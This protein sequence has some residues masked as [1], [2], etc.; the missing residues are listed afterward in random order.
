MKHKTESHPESSKFSWIVGRLG[1]S[2]RPAVLVALIAALA[3]LCMPAMART[4]DSPEVLEAQQ[5]TRLLWTAGEFELAIVDTEALFERFP[6][7]PRGRSAFFHIANELENTC[8]V[9]ARSL[10]E[11]ADLYA[12]AWG[13]YVKSSES[14]AT[15]SGGSLAVLAERS[16]AGVERTNKLIAEIKAIRDGRIGVRAAESALREYDA[17]LAAANY[18]EEL[19]AAGGENETKE[20]ELL[21]LLL[22][23]LSEH[24]E[25]IAG[26]MSAARNQLKDDHP[27]LYA[28]SYAHNE[29]LEAEAV[30]RSIQTATLAIE[31][32]ADSA[33]YLDYRVYLAWAH[34]AEA[35]VE[36]G[37]LERFALADDSEGV[38][39]TFLA[40]VGAL[41]AVAEQRQ[42]IVDFADA[43]L[44][45]ESAQTKMLDT[46]YG[47]DT[48]RNYRIRS[49]ESLA[50]VRAQINSLTSQEDTGAVATGG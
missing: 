41:E 31:E 11:L 39:R 10:D 35:G 12:R 1:G 26:R 30:G 33:H 29:S 46:R 44:G 2:A 45:G 25:A 14:A 20:D 22:I 18:L 19:I 40:I 17:N 6:D 23:N 15:Q 7:Q 3:S 49:I 9:E 21:F 13:F 8:V 4:E 50:E 36:A 47:A 37:R 27:E 42:A 38:E 24:T 48:L 28:R 32:H 5:A 16:S 34:G 43:R